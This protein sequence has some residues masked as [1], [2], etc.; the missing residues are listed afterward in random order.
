MIWICLW[1]VWCFWT[2]YEW[3]DHRINIVGYSSDTSGI[4]YIIY[5]YIHIYIILYRERGISWRYNGINMIILSILVWWIWWIQFIATAS[6]LIISII[7]IVQ[8]NWCTGK[9]S[10]KPIGWPIGKHNNCITCWKLMATW[11]LVHTIRSHVFGCHAGA[12]DLTFLST[13]Y[14]TCPC[15]P[16]AYQD[17]MLHAT[18]QHGYQLEV[19]IPFPIVGFSFGYPRYHSYFYVNKP[20]MQIHIHK[21]PHYL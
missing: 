9:S 8:P 20:N 7:T 17:N 16:P 19:A 21:H 15:R 10:Y 1:G 6:T 4:R 11:L 3:Y 18:K 14:C 2:Y 13:I 5:I 12:D